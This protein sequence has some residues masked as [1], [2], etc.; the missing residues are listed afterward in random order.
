MQRNGD[1]LEL[2]EVEASGGESPHIVRYV[3]LFS[4]LLAVVALSAIWITG[5][6]S[7]G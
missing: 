1:D 2:D 3:L 5:A 7:V 6:L 4:L